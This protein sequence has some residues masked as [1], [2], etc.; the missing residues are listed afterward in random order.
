M[1]SVL[2]DMGRT[3]SALV[4]ALVTIAFTRS[5]E[6]LQG[7]EG[8]SSLSQHRTGVTLSLHVRSNNFSASETFQLQRSS[9]A[10]VGRCYYFIAKLRC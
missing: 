3:N 6:G 2:T 4:A 10:S 8:K 9:S 7:C 5:E 1:W